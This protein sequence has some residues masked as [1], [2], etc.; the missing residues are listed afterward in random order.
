M[1]HQVICPI[2]EINENI[3]NILFEFIYQVLNAIGLDLEKCYPESI[4]KSDVTIDNKIA[5]RALLNK[6]E[7]RI[8]EYRDGAL[9]ISFKENKIARW[10]KPTLS[11]K[12]EDK[13]LVTVINFLYWTEFDGNKN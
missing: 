6:F 12:Q 9:D 8:Q 1:N 10:E 4:K 11:Y 2:S 3:N 13:K 7:L 5:L